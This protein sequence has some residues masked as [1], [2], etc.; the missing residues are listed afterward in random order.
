VAAVGVL[1]H[2]FRLDR[3]GEARPTRA[4]VE[5]VNRGEQRLTRDNIDVDA[6][7]LVIQILPGSGGLRAVLLRYAILLRRES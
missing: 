6:R 5:L 3:L 1:D 2:I 4:A 7:L